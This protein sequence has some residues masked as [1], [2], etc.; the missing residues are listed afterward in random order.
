M[1]DPRDETQPHTFSDDPLVPGP[2]PRPATTPDVEPLGTHD[3]PTGTGTRTNAGSGSS[4]RVDPNPD[5]R[6]NE[7]REPPWFPPGDKADRARAKARDRGPSTAAV[8]VGLILIAIGLYFFIDRTLGVDLPDLRW[9]AIWPVILIVLGAI[10]LLRSV[11][12]A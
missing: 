4:L 5:P 1:T 8:V 3:D 7:W 11:R 9:N 2:T 6:S 12:R 10:V